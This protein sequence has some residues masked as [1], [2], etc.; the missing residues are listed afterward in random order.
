MTADMDNQTSRPAPRTVT[1]VLD[2][3]TRDIAAGH[4]GDAAAPQNEARRMLAE[5]KKT[6]SGAH[7][8]PVGTRAKTA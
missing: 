7:A 5:F 8:A 6:H 2:A 4:V 3:S 1:E